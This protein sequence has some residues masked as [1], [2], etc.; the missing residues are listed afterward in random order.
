MPAWS[1]D[2]KSIAFIGAGESHEQ[3]LYVQGAD[4]PTAV[5]ISRGPYKFTVLSAVL[6]ARFARYL[7]SLRQGRRLRPLPHPSR[8]RGIQTDSTTGIE[9]LH[10]ARW[11]NA[12]YALVQLHERFNLAS[13]D[14]HAARRNTEAL[15]AGAVPARLALQ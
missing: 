6:D 8:R 13:D 5:E 9:R 7:L 2:G 14:G 4:S 11:A 3:Q 15:L 1:P 12:R 10:F